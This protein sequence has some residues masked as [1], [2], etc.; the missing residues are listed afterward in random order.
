MPAQPATRRQDWGEAPDVIGFVGRVA[1]LEQC[2]AWLEL[3]RCRV[4]ALLGMGGIGKTTLAARL[5]QDVAPAFQFL[6]WRSLRDA[7][8]TTEWLAGAIGFLSDHQLVPPP[9]ESERLT[10]LLQLLRERRCLLVLDNFETLLEPGQQAGDYRADLAAYGRILRTIGEG[11]HQSCLLVT[12]REAPPEL[13]TLVGG[14]RTLELA[15]LQSEESQVLLAHNR[16][17][18]NPDEWANLVGRFG[19]NGLALKLVGER[20]HQLFGGEISAFLREESGAGNAFGRVRQLLAEQIER[21]SALEQ[22]VLR[23]LAVEREPVSLTRLLAALGPTAGRG[24]VLDAVE[25]LRRR[26]LVERVE[27]DETAA[28]TL[29]AVV[30]EY[31]TDWLVETVS[32]EIAR[33]EPAQ[34]L[35]RPL[36]NAQAREYVRQTQERLIATPILRLLSARLGDNS[37]IQTRLVELLER[38]RGRP[39]SEQGSGPGTVVTLL[40]LLRGGDLRGFDFS[41]LSLLQAY[42]AGVEAQ[43][44]SLA[45]A[46]LV[47]AVL[48]EAFP[49]PFR[50]A[51][52]DDG[53][54]M[55]VGTASGQIWLY[56]VADRTPL[57]VIQGHASA[58]WG[59][60][61]SASGHRQHGW[62]RETVGGAECPQPCGTVHAPRAYQRDLERAAR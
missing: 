57:L 34:L 19:G 54:L 2:R 25:A 49:P 28:F 22:E 23:L 18:G 36:V 41:R 14:A 35:A 21:G 15:G 60:A 10:A 20:I 52:S 31:V 3:D 29:Q 17:I 30:L 9:G 53:G 8:Q 56:R 61:L 62:H 59:L 55:A 26:C 40:R 39:A 42:L 6:Y 44:T 50:V 11:R 7:P 46:H 45:E 4:L 12:S 13:A 38:W 47:D 5:A 37:A 58:V 43:D 33:G 51:L 48:A 24:A 27:T 32:G 1:E 16:L